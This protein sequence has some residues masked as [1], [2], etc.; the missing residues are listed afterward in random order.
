MTLTLDTETIRLIALF[1]NLTGAGV[2]DC[3]VDNENGVVYF[4]IDEGQVGKAIGKNG[5][6]VKNTEN[7]I[8]KNIKIFEFSA[9]VEKFARNLI[10][11]INS[12]KLRSENGR[13]IVNLW[14]NKNDKA[15]VIG[16]DGRNLKIYKEL[17][18][19]HH[20]INEVI[21]R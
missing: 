18:Q 7:L 11:Q 1:E 5:S 8:K 3:L 10:P 4:V 20:D 21:V 13:K 9:D 2:R 12:V 15:T 16:R 19:R 14:V 17:L 6:S